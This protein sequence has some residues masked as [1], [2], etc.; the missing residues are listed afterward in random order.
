MDSFL[1]NQKGLEEMSIL[2]NTFC[3]MHI[4]LRNMHFAIVSILPLTH[5]KCC[6]P[7]GRE[8]GFH[9]NPQINI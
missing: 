7:A 1:Q 3:N 6:V 8:A 2:P 5:I 4:A 9:F